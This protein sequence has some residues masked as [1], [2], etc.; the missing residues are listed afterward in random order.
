MIQ[1]AK[2]MKKT[3]G[4]INVTSYDDIQEL[5]LVADA[6]ISDYSAVMFSFLLT[7]KPC[8]LYVPD[9][10][11]YINKDRKLY[12]SIN[13]LPFDT[14]KNNDELEGSILNFNSNEYKDKVESMIQKIGS[15]ED[16]NASKNL[17]EKIETI[18][19]GGI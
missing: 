15:Y 19:Y 11:E 16:G 12:F 4:V 5:L 8:F 13:E 14:G 1:V 9:L 6:L 18:V 7:R 10:E 3:K 2:D 17:V